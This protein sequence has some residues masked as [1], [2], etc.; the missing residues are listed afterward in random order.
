MHLIHAADGAFPSDMATGD[1]EGIA[2][3]RRLF[4]VALTRARDALEINVPLR[5]HHH[6]NRLDDRHGYAPLSRYLSP[7]VQQLMDNEHAGPPYAT[8]DLPDAGP[9]PGVSAVDSMLADLWS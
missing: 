1:R 5:Y 3:E 9:G 8:A 4:Y 6:R 2:E 7:A